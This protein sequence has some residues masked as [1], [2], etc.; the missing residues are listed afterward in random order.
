MAGEQ[1][2]YIYL[3][4]SYQLHR[5]Y[6]LS[7]VLQIIFASERLNQLQ[8]NSLHVGAYFAQPYVDAPLTNFVKCRGTY[9]EA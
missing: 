9:N 7:S 3:S 4:I 1:S 5:K 2:L 8:N 6:F